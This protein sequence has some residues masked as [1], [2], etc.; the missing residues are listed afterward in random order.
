MQDN[1]IQA[2]ER[3]ALEMGVVGEKTEHVIATETVIVQNPESGINQQV[4]AGQRVPP[5]LVDAYHNAVGGV[6]AKEDED[7]DNSDVELEK[8]SRADLD[9]KAAELGVIEPEKL[10]NKGAV[11]EAIQ[12]ASS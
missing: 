12:D 5:D 10:A 11:I 7:N 9:T 1:S 3:S 6:S 2:D 8:L 4:F